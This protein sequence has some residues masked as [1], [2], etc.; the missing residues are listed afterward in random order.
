MATSADK[1]VHET[2]LITLYHLPFWHYTTPLVV[3]VRAKAAEKRRWVLLPH[4]LF[5][6]RGGKTAKQGQPLQTISS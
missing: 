1:L 4:V 5:D 3:N 2:G 6:R